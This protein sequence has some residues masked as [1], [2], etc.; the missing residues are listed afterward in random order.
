MINTNKT[1]KCSFCEKELTDKVL[2]VKLPTGYQ[3]KA[4]TPCF[5]H[6]LVATMLFKHSVFLEEEQLYKWFPNIQAPE[7][8][9]D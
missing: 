3:L 5:R 8:S 4:C 1:I 9:E 6:V 7:E 2:T